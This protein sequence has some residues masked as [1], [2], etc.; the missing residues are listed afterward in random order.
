MAACG[1][2][3]AH[4]VRGP[5]R[6]APPWRRSE[7]EQ[8]WNGVRSHRRGLLCEPM[9]EATGGALW[10]PRKCQ[11]S[12]EEAKLWKGSQESGAMG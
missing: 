6:G 1:P 11:S 3:R 2:L 12:G 9:L 8:D 4:L 10:S 7:A 5:W